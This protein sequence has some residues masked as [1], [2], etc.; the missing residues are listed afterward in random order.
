MFLLSQSLTSLNL[1]HFRT[2]N[3]IEISNMFN[4]KSLDLSNFDTHKVTNL[5]NMFYMCSSHL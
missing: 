2:P 3:V 1:S 5:K 4:L